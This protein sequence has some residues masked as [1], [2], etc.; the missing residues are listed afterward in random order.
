MALLD[1]DKGKNC[2]EVANLLGVTYPTVHSLK[3]RFNKKRLAALEEK[4]RPGRPVVISPEQEARIAAI[5][6]GKPPGGVEQWSLRLLA[7]YVVDLGLVEEISHT[8]VGII[9]KN[10]E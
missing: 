1:L 2:R 8:K 6:A 7:K 9:L 10:S 5:A 3:K 4:P